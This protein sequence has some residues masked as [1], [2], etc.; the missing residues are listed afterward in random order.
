[1]PALAALLLMCMFS[2]AGIPPLAGFLGKFMLFTAAAAQGHYI[3]V[4]IAVANAVVSFY[5]Y[6]LV[7]K[8]AYIVDAPG[9]D[10]RGSPYSHIS[11]IYLT[12]GQKVLV[13]ILAA[14]LLVLGLCPAVSD[15][16][17]ARSGV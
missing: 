17:S 16:L 14:S 4:G 1:S 2:L 13:G 11:L 10:R 9:A 8:Q 12:P 6:M 15:W 3:V 5:Y 7:V